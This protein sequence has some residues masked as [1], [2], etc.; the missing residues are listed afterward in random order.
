MYLKKNYI[1]FTAPLSVIWLYVNLDW[2]IS[3]ISFISFFG[4]GLFSNGL[5]KLVPYLYAATIFLVLYS[6]V[7]ISDL[8]NL[9]IM[10]YDMLFGFDSNDSTTISTLTKFLS[11]LLLMGMG[12]A[13]ALD[14]DADD[15]V[16][17]V[18]FVL[19]IF[20]DL[21]NGASRFLLFSLSSP[22]PEQ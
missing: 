11:P 3:T 5:K 1:F 20:F 13:I 6:P 4:F 15:L 7:F 10:G 19:M 22:P 8:I 16:S 18:S 21:L 17:G 12:K 2:F 9:I 14:L